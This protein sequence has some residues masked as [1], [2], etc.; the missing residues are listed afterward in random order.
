MMIRLF[1]PEARHNLING[2]C[3]FVQSGH[4]NMVNLIKMLMMVN[5]LTMICRDYELIL[6]RTVTKDS[7]V[8]LLNF[9][10]MSC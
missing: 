6:L 3:Q 2:L 9:V 7:D 8:E 4:V 10:Y 1:V 5:R